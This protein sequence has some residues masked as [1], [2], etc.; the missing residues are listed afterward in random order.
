[1]LVIGSVI[2]ERREELPLFSTLYALFGGEL[3]VLLDTIERIVELDAPDE[4]ERGED[5]AAAPVHVKV[6]IDQRLDDLREEYAGLEELL[7]RTSA[8][9]QST[10]GPLDLFPPHVLESYRLVYLPQIGFLARLLL[11]PSSSPS[12]APRG[13]D[14]KFRTDAHVFYK[15]GTAEALD[16]RY[17]DMLGAINDRENAIVR[18]VQQEIMRCGDTI[19][20]LQRKVAELDWSAEK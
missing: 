7:A 11:D 5:P 1:M 2:A 3:Q 13:F 16:E 9:D 10:L 17:G 15:S 14:F 12:R 6:G 20:Q 8:S 19:K 18:T 4:R